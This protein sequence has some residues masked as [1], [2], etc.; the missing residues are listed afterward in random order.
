M[1]SSDPH[2]L[3][4]GMNHYSQITKKISS[5]WMNFSCHSHF[6]SSRTTILLFA[7]VFLLAPSW[8]FGQLNQLMAASCHTCVPPPW[9][10]RLAAKPH[11]AEQLLHL[12]TESL[13]FRGALNVA[14]L[15]LYANHIYPNKAS[16]NF[17]NVHCSKITFQPYLCHCLYL[18]T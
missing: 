6:H 14:S 5:E 13:V 18:Q 15:D 7:L 10:Q 12:S 1:I 11:V 17:P 9:A 16:K 2:S 4:S 3:V 8:I